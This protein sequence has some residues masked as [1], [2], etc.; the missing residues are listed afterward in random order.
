MNK[1]VFILI[2]ALPLHASGKSINIPNASIDISDPWYVELDDDTP[3][4]YVKHPELDAE[5]VIFVEKLGHAPDPKT[6]ETMNEIHVHHNRDIQSVS[7]GKFSGYF[8]PFKLED[9][10]HAAWNMISGNYILVVG[11]QGTCNTTQYDK[12]AS[13]IK[14]LVPR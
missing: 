3:S 12:G 14:K 13:I 4:V 7:L 10:C 11:Y 8:I 6:L 5:F 2:F 9:R 1:L